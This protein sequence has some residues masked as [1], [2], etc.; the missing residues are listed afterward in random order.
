MKKTLFFITLVLVLLPAT[1]SA[2]ANNLKKDHVGKWLFEAPYAPQGYTSGIIEISKTD[3]NLS[4]TMAFTGTESKFAGDLVK[5]VKD[6]ITFNVYI[7]NQNVAVKL[8]HLEESK[9][10]GKAIYTE[11]VVPLSL[12]REMKKN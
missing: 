4:A 12:T 1:V 6:T 3:N 11:G 5:I 7:E 8:V 10:S 9:M 2:Q